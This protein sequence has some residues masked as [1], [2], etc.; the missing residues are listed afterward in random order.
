MNAPLRIGV[1]KLADSAPVIMAQQKGIF[2]RH[3]LETEIVVSPSW[4]NIAD[5]LAWNRLDAAVIF[6]PLAMMT[7]L[8]HRGHGAELRPLARISRG[9][10]TIML[11]GINPAS[12]VWQ[13][14]SHG[15]N[16]FDIWRNAIGRKPRIAIVHMYSTHLLILRRFLKMIDVDMENEVTLSV[17]PPADMIHALAE[18]AIDGGCVGPPWGT[19]AEQ[20]GLAFQ[21]G[22]SATVLPGHLE[23][24][25]I[26][27][28]KLLACEQKVSRMS[29]AVQEALSFCQKPAHRE[30]ITQA[31]AAPITDGGLLLPPASTRTILP[32]GE[33]RECVTFS[34]GTLLPSD[35]D[36]IISDMTALGWIGEVEQQM[37]KRWSGPVPAASSPV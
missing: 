20:L 28:G 1:L 35:L 33:A 31:L 2:A 19:E 32:G 37:L 16:A 34:D 17:M 23:K 15:R 26:V 22:G 7:A 30:E 8:G 18:N 21:V 11:R 3:G 10:N 27:S 12:R 5:G 36:W 29:L 25:L 13:A 9:G 4:A 6:A 14:G 24:V